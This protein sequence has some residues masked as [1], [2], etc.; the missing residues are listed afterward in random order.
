MSTRS[1]WTNI[2]RCGWGLLLALAAAGPAAAHGWFSRAPDL[3]RLNASLH[4]TVVDHTRNHG[5][6][7]RL[8]SPALGEYRDLYVYLP[9]GFDPA[10]RY[11]LLLWLHGFAQDEQSFTRDV[12]RPLDQAIAC[13]RLPPLLV[14]APDGSFQGKP[15]LLTAGSFFLNSIAGRFEDYLMRDVWDFLVARYPIRPEREAHVLGGVSMGAGA[16]WNLAI[17]YRDRVKFVVSVFPP[18]N[19]RWQDCHGDPLGDFAPDCA[20][21]RTDF[22]RGHQAV[23]RFFGVVKVP[24]KKVVGPLYGS[25]KDPAVL[26]R[27]SAENPLEMLKRYEVRPGELAAY[28]GY[29]GRDEFNLDAQVESFLYWA[30]P[31]GFCPHVVYEPDGRH[32]RATAYKFIPSVIAWL[33]QQLAAY[34]PSGEASGPSGPEAV[35]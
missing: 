34:Y 13:G 14:A 22:S 6:D 25:G 33:G 35:R 17:K 12:I 1:P 18:L 21:W 9:P 10:R 2:L 26:A 19:P 5:R 15:C 30:R 7:R 28:I 23:G 4:G 24:L 8:W 20:G 16:A 29:G 32:D 3:R 27:V 31:R 11:P